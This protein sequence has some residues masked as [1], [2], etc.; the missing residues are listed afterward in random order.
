M[1]PLRPFVLPK[2]DDA[3]GQNARCRAERVAY[4]A[5]RFRETGI[6]KELD[7]LATL[8]G[9][10][11]VNGVPPCALDEIHALA[12]MPSAAVWWLVR[13]GPSDIEDALS[14]DLHARPMVVCQPGGLVEG[15]RG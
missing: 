7:R 9:T 11:L 2:P 4:C 1:R 6:E 3:T 14:L 5:G 15:L 13:V 10:P 12:Q 8:S